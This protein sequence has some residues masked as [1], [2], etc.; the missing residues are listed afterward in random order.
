MR[1]R[2]GRTAH[3]NPTRLLQGPVSGPG[4][5]GRGLP[6]SP[7]DARTFNVDVWPHEMVSPAPRLEFELPALVALLLNDSGRLPA[8][9]VWR[10]PGNYFPAR[11][12]TAPSP[13][14]IPAA[15]L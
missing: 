11:T 6:V 4:S 3:R 13:I 10:R 15:A 2:L 8:V 5:G 7:W 14:R 9:G 12:V 1:S